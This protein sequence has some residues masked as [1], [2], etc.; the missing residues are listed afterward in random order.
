MSFY[1]IFSKKKE[2]QE[3]NSDEQE[4]EKYFLK[5]IQ[6]DRNGN[7]EDAIKFFTKSL[8]INQN[9]SAVYL[10]RGGC[11]AMQERYLLAHDDYLNVINMEKRGDYIDADTNTPGAL[12]N[13]QRIQA[14][15]GFEQENGEGIRHQLATD[16]GE[17]FTRRWAEVLFDQFLGNDID[18]VNRFIYEEVKDLKELGGMHQKYALNCGVDISKFPDI[19]NKYDANKTF[20]MFKSMLCCFSRDAQKMFEIRTCILNNLINKSSGRTDGYVNF[21][22][23]MHLA[24]VGVDIMFIVKNDHVMYI[25]NDADEL[26]QLNKDGH[27]NL[28]GR[29]VIF[30]YE[31]AAE[32]IEIFVAFDQKD[33][34]TMFTM[35]KGRDEKLNYVSQ[36]ILQFTSQN[37]I[38][39]VFSPT[40][41][42]SSQY[43]YTFKLYKKNKTHFMVNN[44]LS[45]AYLIARDLYK[46]DD[47]DSITSEFWDAC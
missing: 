27:M 38:N 42:Y 22:G 43:H 36:T 5:A 37:N 18:T 16:G 1:N 32:T 47:V 26:Y 19:G 10:N 9:H 14:F 35:N 7:Y 3:R 28:D 21:S 13:M 40:E 29:V 39:N 25:N 2:L 41:R 6:C 45:Q 44:R 20:L 17:H 11:Y 8:E 15:I 12:Q 30:V 34:F 31:S 4:G 24:E 46:S 33:S 23:R